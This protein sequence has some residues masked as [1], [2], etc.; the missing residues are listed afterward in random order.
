ME[1]RVTTGKIRLSYLNVFEAKA[2]T[3]GETPKFS[4]AILLSKKDVAT[5]AKA[6]AAIQLA[7]TQGIPKKW[8]GKKPAILKLPWRDGDEEKP[9]DEAYAGHWFLNASNTKKPILLGTDKRPLEDPSELYSGAYAR[10]VLTFYPFSGKSNGV[11]VSLDSILKLEDG[12]SLGG[13]ISMADA[14]NAFDEEDDL[15]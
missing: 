14:I 15:M 10:A 9:D 4:A 1:T 12:E 5:K 7:I 11:A 3:E 8:K 6:D 13:T 2:M